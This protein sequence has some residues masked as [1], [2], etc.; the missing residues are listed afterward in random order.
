M[1]LNRLHVGRYVT[2]RPV[3]QGEVFLASR[4]GVVA[5]RCVI[6]HKQLLLVDLKSDVLRFSRLDVRLAEIVAC[7]VIKPVSERLRR[8]IYRLTDRLL[9][10]VSNLLI[11]LVVYVDA[12]VA[13]TSASSAFLRASLDG[14]RVLYS[15]HQSPAFS[16]I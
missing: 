14:F 16:F 5:Y 12:E 8:R 11:V 2:D 13:L 7:Q 10:D 4:V 9:L 3:V 15:A 6:G 1:S